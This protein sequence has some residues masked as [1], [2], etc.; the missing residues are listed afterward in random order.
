MLLARVP[1]ELMDEGLPQLPMTIR[2]ALEEQWKKNLAT[3]RNT[4]TGKPEWQL[5]THAYIRRVGI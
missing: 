1:S 4:L 5:L 3:I 2:F